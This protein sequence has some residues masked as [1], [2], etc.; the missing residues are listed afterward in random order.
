MPLMDSY[1]FLHFFYDLSNL[2]QFIPLQCTFL[3]MSRGGLSQNVK[4]L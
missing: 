3:F 4:R 2:W 1:K